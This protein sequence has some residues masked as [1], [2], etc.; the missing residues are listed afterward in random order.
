MGFRGMGEGLLVEVVEEAVGGEV[1]LVGGFVGAGFDLGFDLGD[2][3][4][5]DVV[6]LEGAHEVADAG[7]F[8]LVGG[9]GGGAVGRDL[10]VDGLGVEALKG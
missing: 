8:E 3:V 1:E 10:A 9:A 5:A 2:L 4:G 7:E 6:F